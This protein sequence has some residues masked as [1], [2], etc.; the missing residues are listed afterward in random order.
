M[1][2]TACIEGP[3]YVRRDIRAE[4]RAQGVVDEVADRSMP[5]A[6]ELLE[7]THGDEV[8]RTGHVAV[9]SEHP[10]E[11]ETAYV[12]KEWKESKRHNHHGM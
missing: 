8:D 7:S 1:S 2:D 11:N 6:T 10:Q 4:A 9:A 3:L 12:D 5:D